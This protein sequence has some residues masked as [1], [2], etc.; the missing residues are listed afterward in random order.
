MRKLARE[1]LKMFGGA[2][3][4]DL[5]MSVALRHVF[6]FVTVANKFLDDG[7]VDAEDAQEGLAALM[8]MDSVVGVLEKD[9]VQTLST[10]EE[11]MIRQREDARKRKDFQSSDKIRANLRQRGIILEDTKSGTKWRRFR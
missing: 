11:N 1:G 9:E 7:G 6:D 2:L 5:N 3:E 10:D 8:K 4:E